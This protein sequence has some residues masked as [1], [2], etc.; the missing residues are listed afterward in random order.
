VSAGGDAKLASNWIMTEVLAW[1]NERA[2]AGFPMPASWLAQLIGLV[3]EGR[4]SGHLAKLVFAEA[5]TENCEPMEIVAARGWTQ[6]RDAAQLGEWIESA[7]AGHTD[8]VQRY[9]RGED[10]LFDFFM[11]RVMRLS[12]GRGDPQLVSDLLRARLEQEVGR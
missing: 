9:R 12:A 8:Q 7:L 3:T 5:A 10:R 11:G 2:G 1:R 4:I 6:V